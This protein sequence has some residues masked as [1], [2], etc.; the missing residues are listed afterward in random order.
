MNYPLLFPGTSSFDKSVVYAADSYNGDKFG[1]A[2][3]I[4]KYWSNREK[5]TSNWGYL[6]SRMDKPVTLGGNR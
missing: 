1:E 5:W 2:L 3:K 4:G 6:S